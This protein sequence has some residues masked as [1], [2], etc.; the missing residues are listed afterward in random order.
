MDVWD[1]GGVSEAVG[2]SAQTIYQHLQELGDRE[3]V[4]SLED[5]WRMVYVVTDKSELILDAN[6]MG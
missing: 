2:P 3:N 1:Y 4:S 6:S 5:G